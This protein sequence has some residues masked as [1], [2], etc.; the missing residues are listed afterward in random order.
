[1]SKQEVSGGEELFPFFSSLWGCY[2]SYIDFSNM[3]VIYNKKKKPLPQLNIV[4][5]GKVVK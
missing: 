5:E 3:V 1:M 2:K 4:F